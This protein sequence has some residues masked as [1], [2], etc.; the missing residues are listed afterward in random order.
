M[1][2]IADH[3]NAEDLPQIFGNHNFSE[4]VQMVYNHR[5]SQV[6]WVSNM[7]YKDRGVK[8]KLFMKI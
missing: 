2:Y 1:S 7:N 3:I 5:I 6:E 4:L 8:Q